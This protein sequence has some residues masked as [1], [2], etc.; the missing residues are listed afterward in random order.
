MEEMM[1][2]QKKKAE[3]PTGFVQAGPVTTPPAYI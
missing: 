2:S 3:S 1:K